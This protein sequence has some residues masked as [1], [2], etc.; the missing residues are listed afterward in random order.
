MA[1][2]TARLLVP[3]NDVTIQHRR[4]R[5]ELDAAIAAVVES[6]RFELGR[7]VDAFEEAFAAYCG[8]RY[9]VTVHSGTAAL[10]LA[11]RALGIGPGDEVVTV[12]N[13][14][15]STVAAICFAGA[16]PV[17]V[18]IEPD[19][20]TMDPGALAAALTP[21][22]R[23]VLPVHM[24]GRPAEMAPIL[25]VARRHHLAVIEDAAI[26]TGALYRQARVGSLGEAGAFSFAPGKVL[27]AFGWGG[28]VTTNDGAVARRIRMLRAYGEDPEAYPPPSAGFRGAGLH[29]EVMGWNVR[30]DTIQAA[31]LLVKLPHLEGMIEER[32]TIAVRYRAGLRGTPAVMAD[33]PTHA[34]HVYRNVVVRVPNRDA[35]RLTLYDAGIPT[36]THYV[37]PVHLQPAFQALGYRRGSL[38][39]TDRAAAEL[40]TLPVYPGMTSDQVDLVVTRLQAVLQRFASSPRQRSPR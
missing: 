13:S 3:F 17:L 21:R 4:L 22:T 6:G 18:D 32:R 26:A 36:G 23:A 15:L 19:G 31:V 38:P 25:E 35:V 7:E 40:L 12:A 20:F 9:A 37:P 1:H 16:R 33:D 8:T 29:A 2:P 5:A 28:A 11:L 24:Y 14:D 10:H 34:R 39:E 27:G 30:M